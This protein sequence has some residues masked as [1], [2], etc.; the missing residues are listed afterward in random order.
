MKK[1]CFFA[2]LQENY[3]YLVSHLKDRDDV[4]PVFTLK[5]IW[6][7]DESWYPVN[8][9]NPQKGSND[10][11]AKNTGYYEKRNYDRLGYCSYQACLANV[12]EDPEDYQSDS[13][14]EVE[15]ERENNDVQQDK[16]YHVSVTMT[17]DEGEA[18]FGKCYNCGK[19]GHP[20]HDC[21]KPLKPTLRLALNS[22]IKR[23]A[24]RMGKK[25]LNLNGG[26]RAKGGCIP[27]A[28]PAPAQN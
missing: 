12:R 23:K 10:G 6:E 7:C 8:T 20:W 11:P 27:K 2:S 25:Q 16:S 26:T 15:S 28:P 1:A 18:F 17:A 14:S 22:E 19:P 4:D 13:L 24:R 21:K 3:K 5:E 9:L